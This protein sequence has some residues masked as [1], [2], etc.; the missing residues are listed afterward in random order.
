MNYES[1]LE[2]LYNQLP[3]YQHIGSSAYK[4]GLDNT[5]Q[6]LQ[7]L[8]NPHTKFKTIHVAGTNGKGSVS[9]FLASIFSH[10]ATK[11]DCILRPT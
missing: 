2:Y 6:L 8:D 7:V 11:L 9:H 4:P 1:T 5:N 3:T 10:K